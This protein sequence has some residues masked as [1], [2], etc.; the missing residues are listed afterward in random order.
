ML[1]ADI[2]FA[3]YVGVAPGTTTFTYDARKNGKARK[4]G[5]RGLGRGGAPGMPTHP[6]QAWDI[7]QNAYSNRVQIAVP[8]NQFL[9]R[10]GYPLPANPTQAWVEWPM[11]ADHRVRMMVPENQIK[12]GAMT[13]DPS[14]AMSVPPWQNDLGPIPNDQM[15]VPTRN[16]LPYGHGWVAYK[17]GNIYNLQGALAEAT[18]ASAQNWAIFAS[19]LGAFALATTATLAVL[20]YRRR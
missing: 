7:P 12:A 20:E 17:G 3:S 2:K 1:H 4:N 10:V 6:T 16:Y 18:P 8:P 11:Q 14:I 15:L 19:V 9:P 13:Y 5:F